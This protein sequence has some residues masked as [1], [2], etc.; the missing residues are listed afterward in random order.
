MRLAALPPGRFLERPLGMYDLPASAAGPQASRSTLAW[1]ERI[2]RFNQLDHRG[3]RQRGIGASSRPR[4]ASCSAR[5][6]PKIIFP[7]FEPT[8]RRARQ[9][10]TGTQIGGNRECLSLIT[11]PRPRGFGSAFPLSQ[12][13]R[14]FWRWSPPTSTTLG[15]SPTPC[16]WLV[17]E[18]ARSDLLDP[19]S[20]SGD[21]SMQLSR[22]ALGLDQAADHHLTAMGV[23]VR[24]TGRAQ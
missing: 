3:R 13:S 14:C 12:P 8:P 7:S 19:H 1:P 10:L 18:A 16:R 4:S 17:P 11:K 20:A 24:A 22:R 6:A 15:R 2:E 5:P 23:Q 9:T 21:A